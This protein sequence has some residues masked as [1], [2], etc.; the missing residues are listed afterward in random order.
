MRKET[1]IGMLE[2]SHSNNEQ[3]SFEH[4]YQ[5]WQHTHEQLKIAIRICPKNFGSRLSFPGGR[6]DKQVI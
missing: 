3:L 6:P 4:I 1:L 5:V 2:E